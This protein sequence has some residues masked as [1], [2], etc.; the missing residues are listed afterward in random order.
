MKL[1]FC[2]FLLLAA[3]AASFAQTDAGSLSGRLTDPTG[4]SV[5]SGSLTLKNL[6]TGTTRQTKTS[7]EG[8]YQFNI[9]APGEYEISAEATG[10][11]RFVDNQVFIQVAQATLLN[12]QMAIGSVSETVNVTGTASLLNT[13]SVS[14]GTVITQEKI[15]SLP[16]NGRQ[17][18]DLALLVPGTNSG[19]RAVQ[20]NGVRLNQTGGF[21]ASGGRTNNNLFLLD[22]AINTDPDYNALSYVP[23]IDSIAEFQVQTSQY[24]AQYGRASGGQINVVS[25]SGSNGFHGTAWE[26]LRNQNM[27]ARP[28]NSVTSKLPKNQRNQFGAT[29]GGPILHDKVFFFAGFEAL[30]LRQAGVGITNVIVPTALEREGDFSQTPGTFFDPDTLANGT[31]TAFIGNKIPVTR[32]NSITQA[33]IKAMPLPNVGRNGFVNG[34]AVLKQ[35]SNN[36][37]LRLDWAASS[38]TTVF[39]RYSISDENSVIPDVVTDRDRLGYVRPQNVGFGATTV[40]TPALVSEFRLG[41]NRLM[42]QDGLPEPRFDVNGATRTI[43]RFRTTGYPVM[44]GAGAFTGTTGGGTVLTRDNTYQIYDNV[45]WIH[46]GMTVKF[47]AELLRTSYVR[48]EAAAPQ[49]DF[50]FLQGYTS[51]TAGNDGT[52]NALATMLL[53]LPNQGNRQVT[54]TRIDGLQYATSLYAQV[55]MHLLPTVVVNLGLRYEIA[56]PMR[57]TRHQISSIDY[58]NVPW[59]TQIFATGPLATYKP[60]LFTCGLGGYPEG[61]AYTDKNNFSPRFGISWKARERTVVRAGAGIFYA[62]TDSNGFLQLARGL[63]TNISQNLNAASSFVP[64]FRGFDIFGPAAEVGRVALSQAGLDLFQRTSYSVQGSFTVQH[65]LAK[66]TIVEAG[67]LTTLGIKLQQNVQPNN[68]QP[69]TAAVDPRRPY[70]GVVFDPSMV[71]PSYMN[72]VANSVPVTQVNMYAQSAQSN[73]HALTL[74]FERRFTNGFSLLSSYTFSK[75]ITNA[76]QFRNSGGAGGS[77]NS[78][79]QNTYNLRAERGL[80]SFDMRHRFVNSFVWDLPFGKGRPFVR[81]G[82]ASWILG[83]WQIAGI[84]QMQTGFPFTVN[85]NGDT[86]GIGGGTG[87]ILI[88]PNAVAG[89]TYK[90][91][92]DERTTSRWFNTGAFIAPAAGAFGNVGRNTVI[93][94]GL[95]NLDTTVSRTFVFGDRVRVQIRGE[96]F[97]VANKPNYRL[98]GRLINDSNF[99]KVQSQFDP[100]QIQVGAKLTF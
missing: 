28:F 2:T 40:F 44:G 34:N 6:A 21:S 42:F 31:R 48:S 27:D 81:A 43:P 47:G 24:S 98:V 19:G 92:D 30:R 11:K 38:K 99:G 82:I 51:R 4:A 35:D 46:G 39:G 76:P 75:A 61:C 78:P 50:Q 5:E 1:F 22:G 74:R 17:F 80:A 49:G 95:V 26:F 56:P 13:E 58:R 65:E 63:P 15:V 87:G 62:L 89:A 67:Y 72:V 59:P 53:A 71:F 97:N 88:R 8:L 100:R 41:Y 93:G 37:S 64:S 57:D 96:F 14:Q 36:G 66:N 33:A 86:A 29:V 45:S 9:L 20:Q 84:L 54:P 68:A 73:Y 16:L 90:L 3:A 10:F 18:I 85:L 55:D 69:G 77:E 94:P 23:I 32:I 25:K 7:G 60:T 83:G 70:A 91:P 79:A 52:G 12:I